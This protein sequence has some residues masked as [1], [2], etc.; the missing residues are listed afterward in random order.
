[1]DADDIR[2]VSPSNRMVGF[3]YTKSMNSNWDL[4][5]G[6]A[7]ILCSPAGPSN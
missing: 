5:Q 4:D 1:M 6:A 7:L 3:P 2:E